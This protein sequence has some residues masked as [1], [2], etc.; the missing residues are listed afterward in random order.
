M[1]GLAKPH[2]SIPSVTNDGHGP[3]CVP[4]RRSACGLQVNP[5]RQRKRVVKIKLRIHDLA[6][7]RLSARLLGRSGSSPGC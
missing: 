3:T 2:R 5:F 7:A 4:C 6:S 1:T